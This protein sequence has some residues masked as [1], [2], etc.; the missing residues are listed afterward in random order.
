MN[1]NQDLLSQFQTEVLTV[2]QF[3]TLIK[4]VL[5]NLGIFRV[6]GEIRELTI[7][8]NNGVNISL[9]DGKANLRVGGFAPSIKG[10]DLVEEG[11]DVVV[12]GVADLYVPY[13]S[14]S[15]S[16]FAIEAV[17]E[18]SLAIAYQK[19]KE[20]LEKEG[21]FATEHKQELPQFI[22]K[23]ALLTGKDSAAYS[24]FIKILREHEVAVEILYYPVLVQGK[25]SAKSIT[26]ALVDAREK[27][28]DL[29][30]LTRG[31]GS[32]EDL[33]SFNDEELAQLIFSSPKPV[34]AG[35]GH[36]KDESISDFVADLRASTP[37]Q[38]AYYI[39]EQNQTFLVL[40]G[41]HGEKVAEILQGKLDEEEQKLQ[42]LISSLEADTDQIIDRA[43]QDINA[44][45]RILKSFDFKNTLKRGFAIV[46][47]GKTRVSSVQAVK[48]GDIVDTLLA[49]GSFVSQIDKLTYNNDK[50]KNIKKD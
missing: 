45:E 39:A 22:T 21:L 19:L 4:D 7:T 42:T 37:S 18:G 5:S 25:R 8:Q 50:K 17:G 41:E 23:I 36:E 20:K 12:E 6:K 29:I 44:I 26:N 31:G 49:D 27:N 3:N 28:V 40:V 30:V 9:S 10:I 43:F 34:I 46:Q 47:K 13:G 35:V 2:S 48:Q 24:D 32:L 14:F 1:T 38:A 11:M 15:L 16:A 33:K